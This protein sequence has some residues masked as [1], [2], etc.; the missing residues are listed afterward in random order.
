ML[1]DTQ[2]VDLKKGLYSKQTNC[3]IT[4]LVLQ[5]ERSARSFDILLR[6]DAAQPTAFQSP[7]E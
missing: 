3:R 7:I 4:Q 5:K 2:I 6:L 1:A